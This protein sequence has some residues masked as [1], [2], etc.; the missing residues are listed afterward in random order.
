MEERA[1][2]ESVCEGRE[3]EKERGREGEMATT[4]DKL[5]V[6]L[7]DLISSKKP[8]NTREEKTAGKEEA[9]RGGRRG[10]RRRR[11]KGAASDGAAPAAA[12]LLR[13]VAGGGVGKKGKSN[14]SLLTKTITNPAAK[15]TKYDKGGEG[16]F[17]G[18]RL[19]ITNLDYGVTD[20]DLKQI[21]EDVGEIKKAAIDF[22]KLH[23]R[24]L[25]RAY[26]FLPLES[27]FLIV[28]HIFI[29]T[30]QRV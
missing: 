27:P 15:K 7:D 12:A 25:V 11:S 17:T 19:D 9:G 23:G 16:L 14:A 28:T 1:R 26:V 3:G 8:S 4:Q 2:E 21:F 30:P 24:S 18:T 13:T 20:L 10:G 5:D 6:S 22:D 29:H